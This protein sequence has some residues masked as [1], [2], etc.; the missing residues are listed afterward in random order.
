M[1][2]HITK[3]KQRAYILNKRPNPVVDSQV[4]QLKEIAI[5]EVKDQEMLVQNL[6][7]SIDPTNRIWMEE[8]PSYLPPLPLGSVMRGL[9]GGK[10][11]ASRIEGVQAGDLVVGMGGWSEYSVVG[12]GEMN[13]I[14]KAVGLEA[15]LSVFGHIG[16]TAYFGLLDVGKLKAGETLLVSAAAGATGSLV[17]Q[18]GKIKG[19]KVF[20]TVGSDDKLR[21][22]KDELGF[23][24]GFNYNTT[25][26]YSA[27]IKALAP[28]GIDVYF[29]NV[30]GEMLDAALAQLA[31]RGRIVLCGAISQYNQKD[32]YAPKNY[33]NLLMKRGRM[34][35]FIV[36]DYMSRAMEASKDLA[37]WLGE[38]KLKTK[39]DVVEGFENAL[40]ALSK[41]FDGT[42]S[43]KMLVKLVH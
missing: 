30:G 24:G 37:Q 33:L 4:L 31:M 36:L 29:D 41:L 22:I 27:A 3:S 35:G 15:A 13:V 17:G 23:D 28:R 38:G 25:K 16:V 34:E 19:C 40:N 1:T 26:D 20:G 10:V 9:T 42:N 6:Y 12:K 21:W 7:L 14:P 11:I 5:P 39:V 32:I 43:G 8:K 2:H 18:I